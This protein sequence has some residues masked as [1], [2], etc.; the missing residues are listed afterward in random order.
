ML[1]TKDNAH[2]RHVVSPGPKDGRGANALLNDSECASGIRV[3][4]SLP[5]YVTI[6]THCGCN[7]NCVFCPGGEFPDFSLDVFRSFLEEKLEAALSAA[8]FVGFCGMGELLLI[9]GIE[10]FLD[11]INLNLS[12]ATKLIVSNGS[13]LTRRLC[14]KLVEACSSN[15][16]ET[17]TSYVLVI[18]LH[19]FDP[20]LHKAITGTGCYEEIISSIRYLSGKIK[21]LN[22]KMRLRLAFVATTLNIDHLPDF[23]RS[24]GEL[25]VDGIDCSY[26][27]IYE[28]RH[29]G[30]SCFFGKEKAVAAFE[31]AREMAAVRGIDLK[32]PP[33][34]RRE[35]TAPGES[36]CSD[37]WKYLYAETQGTV[38]PCCFANDHTGDLSRESFESVWNGRPYHDLRRDL[39]EGDRINEF[40]KY[41]LKRDR[42]MVNDIRAHISQRKEIRRSIIEYL[43]EHGNE[44]KLPEKNLEL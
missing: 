19:A 14:D 6:G 12:G 21:G 10:E 15:N 40:C 13:P 31:K 42:G 18:S 44:Y 27:N 30:L 29:I 24:A 37:P 9:P 32:L 3:L 7:A 35:E 33:S 23:V 38:N 20:G 5:Q 16:A 39:S 34:F 28:P 2:L 43:R 26:L 4:K 36:C 17:D 25:G 1:Q 41:C 22:L 8:K 11:Y